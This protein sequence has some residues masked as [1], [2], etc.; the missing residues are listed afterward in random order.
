MLEMETEGSQ[1]LPY[2]S[3]AQHSLMSRALGLAQLSSPPF[4]PPSLQGVISSKVFHKFKL[5]VRNLMK[6]IY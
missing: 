2:G 1:R 4:S 6:A 3:T 5:L